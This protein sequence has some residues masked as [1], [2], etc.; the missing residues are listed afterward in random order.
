MFFENL[1][2]AFGALGANKLRTVLSLLGIIIGVASVVIITTLGT[3]ASESVTGSIAEAGLETITVAPGRGT[4]REAARIFVPELAEEIAEIEGVEHA[5]AVRQ[6]NY[7]LKYGSETY[8]AS[9]VGVGAEYADVFDYAAAE[10]SFVTAADDVNRRNVVVLGAETAETLFPAGDAIGSYLRLYGEQI[11]RLKVVGIMEEKT[12]TFG[13]SFDTAAFIPAETFSYRLD[14]SDT[15]DQFAIGTVEG[16]DVLAV[17][18][19]LEAFLEAEVGSSEGFRVLSPTTIAETFSSVT[20]T[21]SLFLAGVA[22]IS[23]L[24]G[25]IGIMNIMLVS[26]SERTKEIGIRKALGASPRVIRGQFLTEASSLTITGGSLGIGFGLAVSAFVVAAL[27]WTFI[28][29]TTAIGMAFLFS[30]AVGLFFGWYPAVRAS[31][32]DP[33]GALAYE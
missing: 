11:L 1:R 12:A 23:L 17:A 25:G 32:L 10:G 7:T 28:P 5:V 27:G 30:A 13:A 18:E 14:R 33:V 2:L 8:A 9:V 19:S 24:V 29:S 3:A 15:V 21:L 26:V 6:A 16:A 31:R 4:S 20:E 22:A